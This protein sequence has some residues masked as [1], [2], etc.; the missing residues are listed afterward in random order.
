MLIAFHHYTA[1]YLLFDIV[2]SM[3][4]LKR[5]QAKKMTIATIHILIPFHHGT[6]KYLLFEIVLSMRWPMTYHDICFVVLLFFVSM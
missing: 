5:Y 2:W 1:K 3:R 4:W 6:A